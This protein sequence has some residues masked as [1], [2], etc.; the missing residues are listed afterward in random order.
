MFVSILLF[1]EFI[2]AKILLS[3][4]DSKYL[5]GFLQE[6]FERRK[7][8]YASYSL[9]VHLHKLFVLLW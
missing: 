3:F 9:N 4:E 8:G 1:V 5:G 7:T 6:R 2:I